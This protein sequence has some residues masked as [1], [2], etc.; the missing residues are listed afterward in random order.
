MRL[1]KIND[2]Q[3]NIPERWEEVTLEQLLKVNAGCERNIEVLTIFTGLPESELNK[4][5]GYKTIE[6][7]TLT[8]SY[9]NNPIPF[10]FSD[11]PKEIVFKQEAFSLPFDLGEQTI[12]QYEDMKLVCQ[13][14]YQEEGEEIDMIKRLNA[15]VKAVSIY[16][17]PIVDKSDYDYKRA[18]AL[19]NE[20][21]KCSAV[22][23]ADWGN[24]FIRKFTELRAGILS[25]V[26]ASII[27]TK[28]PKQDSRNS[29]RI[30][31]S[32]LHYLA[33]LKGIFKSKTTY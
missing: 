33:S 32:T 8:L 9:L 17:Q 21:F 16:L 13:E 23:V 11:T 25:S 20:I 29:Q 4:S 19:E 7:I 6:E 30:L 22:E 3:V 5:K 15:Y 1:F 2:I 26:Q 24:F 27:P 31:A 14:Y 10:S 18:E 28:K 12:A